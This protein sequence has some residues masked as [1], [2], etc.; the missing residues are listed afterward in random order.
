[1]FFN[2]NYVIKPEIEIFNYPVI[3]N[4]IRSSIFDLLHST[5]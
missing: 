3:S 2:E 5:F 1:M 4:V